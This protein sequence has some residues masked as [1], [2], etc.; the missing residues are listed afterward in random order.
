MILALDCLR[1][2][3]LIGMVDDLFLYADDELL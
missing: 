2:K 3:K 1:I